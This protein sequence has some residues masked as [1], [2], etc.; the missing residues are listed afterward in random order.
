MSERYPGGL[1]TKTPVTPSGQYGTNTAP[2]IWTLDQALQYIKAG[3]WPV[4]GGP[5]DLYFPYVTML[6]HGDGTNGAQNN[7]FLDSSTN[8]FSITRNG[9]T[10]QG[11]FSPYGSNWSNYFSTTGSYFTVTNS[12]AFTLGSTFTVECWVYKTTNDDCTFVGRWYDANAS[13]WLLHSANSTNTFCFGTGAGTYT[14]GT[15]TIPLNTWTHL[16][17]SNDA[18]SKRMY[19]NGTLVNTYSA[20]NIS[21]NGSLNLTINQNTGGG[22]G[23][24]N[25]MSNLRIV[26]GTALYTSNFTPSTTPLTAISGTSLLTCQSNR[27]IDNSTNAFAITAT[28][29]PSVQR[30]SPFSPTAAYS[31][32]VIGGSGYFDGSGDYLDASASAGLG[33]SGNFTLQ[34]WLYPTTVAGDCCFYETRGGSGWVFFIN[35]SGYLQVYD[36]SATAQTASTTQLKANQWTHIALVKNGSTCTYYVNGATAGTFTLGT[37][38]SATRTRVGS[39]NDAA[40]SYFG[41]IADLRTDT[42]ALTITVPTAPLTAAANT[43]YLLNFTNGG[44]FDNAMMN[45]LETVGNAQISTS[46]FKYG[47]GSLSFNNSTGTYL[48]VPTSQNFAFQGDFT[49]EGWLYINAFSAAD[50]SFFD[51][52]ATDGSSA[53]LWFG[54]QGTSNKLRVY[55]AASQFLLASTTLSAT[56]WTHVAL[57]RSGSTLTIYQNGTSVASGTLTASLTDGVCRIALTYATSAA[58]LNGYI[59]DLRITKGY[60]RYTTTF[61]PPTAAFLNN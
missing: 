8:N 56:T 42:T 31:T 47:T 35:S 53:G 48:A 28:G 32:S 25:Y 39:R 58:P 34:A 52:R 10:T 6:L 40:Q 16:A 61:T 7:T 14:N 46:V 24:I 23:G 18:T 27:F 30:F 13:A 2:G 36:S 5:Y 49:V 22:Y 44:I 55:T 57:V 17:V 45:N 37:F 12:A 11:S 60:A 3:S 51:S 41:W 19:V 21:S 43:N 15:A 26:K 59:D 1:I 33:G 20:D 29:S 54:I 38:Q 9:N 50:Q 4:Q